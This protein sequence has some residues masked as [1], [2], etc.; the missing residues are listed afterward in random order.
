MT[1]LID[2]GPSAAP[3][4][5]LLAHGAGAP[6]T[7]PFLERMAELLA[8]RGLA[9]TRFEF[10]YMAGRRM[11]GARRPAPKA[12]AL[13]PAYRAVIDSVRQTMPR[14]QRL[15]IGGKSMGGRIASMIA[16]ELGTAGCVAGLVCLGYPFRPPRSS[17]APRIAH[18]G[19]GF[20]CP[21]LI[22]QGERDPFGGRAD[23][24]GYGLSSAVRFHWATDGDHDLKPRAAS[25]TTHERNLA[26]AADAVAAF[27]G[28]VAGAG[29]LALKP[30]GAAPG[31]RARGRRT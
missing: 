14:G 17:G 20:S 1:D 21:A 24:A 16:G 6:M 25:G 29:T 27:A 8:G 4:R 5:L 2:N 15:L 12:E 10:D 7:S 30:S 11:G 31:P 9:V 18:L 26:A 22:V 28:T 3:V 13:I 23:V 19:Q